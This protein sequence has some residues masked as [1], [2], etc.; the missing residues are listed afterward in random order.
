MADILRVRCPCCGMRLHVSQLEYLKNLKIGVDDLLIQTIGGRGN[1][2][3]KARFGFDSPEGR[4]WG[5]FFLK[6]IKIVQSKLA[7]LLGDLGD[8]LGI[9]SQKNTEWKI[10]EPIKVAGIDFGGRLEGAEWT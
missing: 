1:C 2:K 6:K 9:L 5:K 4:V 8:R 10:S 3:T 7:A